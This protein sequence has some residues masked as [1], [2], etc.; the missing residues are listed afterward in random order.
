[1]TAP[2]RWR[3]TVSPP[4][5]S[6]NS[7]AGTAPAMSDEPTLDQAFAE[8]IVQ[9]LMQRDQTNE[10]AIRD[11]LQ[12][13]AAAR[14][15]L[16]TKADPGAGAPYMIVRLLNETTRLWLRR[17]N[18]EMRQF[19]GMTRARCAVLIELAQREPVSQA[20]LAQILGITGATLV[21]LLDQLETAGFIARMP[22]PHDRR[23]HIPVLTARALPVV[24]YIYDLDRK[25]Y[26][27]ARLGL[28]EAEADQLR[29]LLSRVRSNIS[30][31]KSKISAAETGMDQ[32]HDNA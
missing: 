6:N 4:T 9:Q 27:A 20:A 5:A 26:G 12:H 22:A 28:S 30:A 10:A 11:L 31:H 21:R 15:A 7:A 19:P 3:D 32:G 18:R 24:E 23:A 2:Q 16:R 8:P 29:A 13:T 1:M 17:Y 14:L 25:I